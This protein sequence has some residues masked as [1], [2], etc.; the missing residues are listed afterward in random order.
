MILVLFL[1][2][3]V[4][5]GRFSFGSPLMTISRCGHLRLGS[6]NRLLACLLIDFG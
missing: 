1:L 5:N 2:S 4:M 6:L 3:N